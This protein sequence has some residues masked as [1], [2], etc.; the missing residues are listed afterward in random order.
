[1]AD[2]Y[3][4]SADRAED[5]RSS[6]W[7]LLLVGGIGLVIILLGAFGVIS[8]PS[9]FSKGLSGIVLGGLCVL[10]IVMGIVSFKK[11]VTYAEQALKEGDREA[12]VF[13]WFDENCD[14]EKIDEILGAQLFEV[15]EEEKYLLRFAVVQKILY[16]NFPDLGKEFVEH[17]ANAVY[18]YLYGEE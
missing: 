4:N 10:F 17:M 7:T 1:M 2:K 9:G 3:M 5:N 16:Q 12:K 6:A 18:E 13:A 14:A 11:S 8:V 15:Q